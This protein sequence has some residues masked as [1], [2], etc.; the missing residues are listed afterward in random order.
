MT[1]LIERVI[2]SNPFN[3]DTEGAIGSTRKIDR[4][5]GLRRFFLEREICNAEGQLFTV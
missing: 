5:P 1:D 4:C 2:R 3:M